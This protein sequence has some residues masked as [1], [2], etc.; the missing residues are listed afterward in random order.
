MYEKVFE[1]KLIYLCTNQ[2]TYNL[3]LE[4]GFYDYLII[5]EASQNDLARVD[6]TYV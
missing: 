1:K 5:D 6:F 4:K 3:P 2:S